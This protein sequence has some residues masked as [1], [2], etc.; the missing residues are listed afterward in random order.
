M[1]FALAG[2]S[3]KAEGL[4]EGSVRPHVS[5]LLLPHRVPKTQAGDLLEVCVERHEDRAGL[6]GVCGNPDIVDGQGHSYR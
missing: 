4:G 5:V 1:L 6:D 2:G 3:L